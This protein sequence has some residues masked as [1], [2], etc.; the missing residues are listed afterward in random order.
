MAQ[1][2]Q[3]AL[4]HRPV[5]RLL[6]LSTQEVRLDELLVQLLGAQTAHRVCKG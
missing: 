2:E 6:T 4:L 5:G 1:P 3:V